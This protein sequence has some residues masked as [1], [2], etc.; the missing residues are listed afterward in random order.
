MKT[1]S[2]AGNLKTYYTINCN[3]KLLSRSKDR[4][5]D[6]MTEAECL[7]AWLRDLAG[8]NNVQS[9]KCEVPRYFDYVQI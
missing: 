5:S 7:R 2:L 9:G 8:H 4:G 3:A 1:G 6:Q